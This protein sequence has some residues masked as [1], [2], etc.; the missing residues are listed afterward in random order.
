MIRNKDEVFCI[1]I[2]INGFKWKLKMKKKSFSRC[3]FTECIKEIWWHIYAAQ[4]I[5]PV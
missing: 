1:G 4:I 3:C 2:P 5:C